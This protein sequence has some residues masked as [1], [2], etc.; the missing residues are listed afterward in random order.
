MKAIFISLI[1][2]ATLLSACGGNKKSEKEITA[3]NDTV[4]TQAPVAGNTTGSAGSVNVLVTEY[5]VL[6]NA[7][8]SD[9]GATAASAAKNIVDAISKNDD[10]TF[11]ADQKKL[12]DDVKDDMK[13]HAEHISANAGKLDHQREHFDMLSQDM[14]DM[15][16]VFKPSQAL[17]QTHCPM[18]NDKKG[19]SWLSETKEIKNP[20]YGKKMLD[21]GMVKE[22]LMP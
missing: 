17:Y 16:K 2:A 7:L 21:C 12:F 13:E 6:K 15:V 19:A 10:A 9:D 22:E 4:Q 5:L 1:T 11:T 8:V 20:Y 3:T 14:Y 18:F